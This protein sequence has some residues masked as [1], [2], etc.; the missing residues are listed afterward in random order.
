MT[1]SQLA[2]SLVHSHTRTCTWQSSCLTVGVLVA[3]FSQFKV[4]NKS[5][6]AELVGLQRVQDEWSF[7]AQSEESVCPP[8]QSRHTS[9]CSSFRVSISNNKI[10]Q[11]DNCMGQCWGDSCD[12]R[13][14]KY[15]VALQGPYC[16]MAHIIPLS[17]S[18]LSHTVGRSMLLVHRISKQSARCAMHEISCNPDHNDSS[19][20]YTYDPNSET[21]PV[22]SCSR[23]VCPVF[24]SLEIRCILW[25]LRQFCCYALLLLLLFKNC[26][27]EIHKWTANGSWKRR[28]PFRSNGISWWLWQYLRDVHCCVRLAYSPIIHISLFSNVSDLSQITLLTLV[29]F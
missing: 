12:V 4:P 8:H 2:H 25:W 6:L 18:Q 21:V 24:C 19:W 20:F 5:C 22:T 16:R 3:G 26:M 28:V 27:A 10:W 29:H 7:V 17:S 14:D 1:R 13:H 9:L 23:C 11:S 15:L